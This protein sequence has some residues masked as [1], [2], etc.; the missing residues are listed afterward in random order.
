[1]HKLAFA[2]IV[3]T[4][5]GPDMVPSTSEASNF[6]VLSTRVRDLAQAFRF[7]G[8]KV[9][10]SA[11]GGGTLVVEAERFRTKSLASIRRTLKEILWGLSWSGERPLL[12]GAWE[13]EVLCSPSVQLWIPPGGDEPVV[14]GVFEQYIDWSGH[15]FVGA[16]PARITD[17][18]IEQIVNQ[19][20]LLGMLFQQLG[21]VGRCSFDA[22]LVGQSFDDARLEFVEC[23]GRW[24]GTST[25][26]T[27]MN[28]LFGDWMRQPYAVRECPVDG[29]DRFVLADLMQQLAADLWDSRT[30]TG[31]IILYNPDR[32]QA[33]AAIN[34]LALGET[35]EG[36]EALVCATVPEELRAMVAAETTTQ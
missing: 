25:P 31:R 21:Y 15:S 20:S 16:R 32:M 36:A 23:N 24:G 8:L 19:C 22:L 30:G 4:L 29:L 5:L 7:V 18:S 27:L 34:I 33:H 3:R 2:D 10:D 14:E 28:R 35:W 9:P 12:V 26:M 11:G 6:A 1:N 13:T 17:A